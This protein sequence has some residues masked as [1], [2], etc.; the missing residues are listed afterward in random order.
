MACHVQVTQVFSEPKNKNH[1]YNLIEDG[2]HSNSVSL[3][4]SKQNIF[5]SS[6][7]TSGQFSNKQDGR[8]FPAKKVSEDFSSRTTSIISKILGGDA[9]GNNKTGWHTIALS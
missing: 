2:H 3:Q 1:G 4:V 9:L 6:G 7:S 8:Y 5:K